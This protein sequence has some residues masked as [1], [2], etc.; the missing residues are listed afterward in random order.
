MRLSVLSLLAVISLYCAS[1]PPAAPTLPQTATL[2]APEMISIPDTNMFRGSFSPEGEHFYF[3]R[4]VMPGEEDYRIFVA[5]RTEA[6]W[7]APARLDLGGDYSDLYPTVSPDGQR[8]V[9]ASY[10]PLPGETVK[11][12][13]NLWY[14]DWADDGW[15]PPVYMADASTPGN[16]DSG[17]EYGPDG[18]VYFTS[19]SPDWR[20]RYPR[21]T[22]WTGDGFGPHQPHATP[23]VDRWR[24]WRAG[25]FVWGGSQHPDGSLVLLYISEVDTTTRRPGPTDMW[26]TFR[27]GGDWTEPRRLGAGVNTPAGEGFGLFSPDGRALYFVRDFARYYWVDL[28]AAVGPRPGT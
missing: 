6:G 24:D 8:L 18:A 9:F 11:R 16:Y 10:R 17:P 26:V 23:A 15:G 20:S 4:K 21:V 28:E 1:P 19:I 7:S 5:A 12:S 2:F 3:F 14:S 13:A 27:D 22:R 25:T